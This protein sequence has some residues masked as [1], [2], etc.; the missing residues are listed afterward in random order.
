VAV[1]EKLLESRGVL[2][3]DAVDTYVPDAAF[4]AELPV[5]TPTAW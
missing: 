3:K 1:L 4:D 5:R 2:A